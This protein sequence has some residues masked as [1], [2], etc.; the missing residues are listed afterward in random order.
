MK[1]IVDANVLISYLLAKS[2]SNPFRVLIRRATEGAFD[3]LVSEKTIEEFAGS[4]A[5]K[6]HLSRYITPDAV[7]S[8]ISLLRIIADV[9]PEPDDPIEIR[10]RDVKDDYLIAHTLRTGA[11]YLVTGDKDL[12][13]FEHDLG[14]EIV[15]PA[16]FV[17]LLNAETDPGYS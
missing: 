8:L 10:T 9:A 13:E 2:E 3:L 14:F 17:A 12:L 7:E 6:P 15:N 1:V 16:E 4:A 5:R 11:D